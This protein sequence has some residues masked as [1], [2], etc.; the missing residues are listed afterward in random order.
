MTTAASA[1][2]ALLLVVAG[3]QQASPDPTPVA[4]PVVTIVS[5]GSVTGGGS[6]QF[7]VRAAPAPPVDLRVEVTITSSGCE[8]TQSAAAVTIPAGQ[9]EAP[10]TVD[11]SGAEVGADGFEVTAAIAADEGYRVGD[12]A[13][14]AIATITQPVT[15]TVTIARDSASVTEGDPVSFTL[16]ASPTPAAELRVMVDWS[17]DGSFLTGT[18]QETVVIAV[19]GTGRL[20]ADTDDDGADEPDGSVTVTVVAGSGYSVGS[21]SSAT[22]EVN[23]NDTTGGT[24]TPSRVPV[25]TI[26]RQGADT[27][28]EGEPLN[29]FLTIRPPA[30]LEIPVGHDAPDGVTLETGR[31]YFSYVERGE[32]VKG[33]I[34][35]D[36]DSTT[37]P[38]A[39][40]TVT[41]LAGSGYTVGS[42]SSV[43]FTVLDDD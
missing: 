15:P 4:T 30:N 17:E 10:L 43:Q 12:A 3:C 14:T 32:T 38:D 2:I 19:D 8:L 26:T 22:V 7:H 21:P 31:T 42:P 28:T 36:R 41:V 27:V 34:A 18:R 33:S 9:S 35:T 40:V 39:T 37:E 24:P 6:L 29:F 23:D 1:A 25:V 20:T 11:T 5:A 16:T 13:A